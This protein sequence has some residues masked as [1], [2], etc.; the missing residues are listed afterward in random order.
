[1]TRCHIFPRRPYP[2]GC[3]PDEGKVAELIQM[4][5]QNRQCGVF[6]EPAVPVLRLN[7]A[8]DAMR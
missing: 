5:I 1:M 2:G 8:L 3:R 6:G 7:I 4:H